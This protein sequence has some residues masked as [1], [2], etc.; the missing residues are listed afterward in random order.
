MEIKKDNELRI[1]F[2]D[3][4]AILQ[5]FEE[6]LDEKG[7][8]WIREL[9][10]SVNGEPDDYP[11]CRGEYVKFMVNLLNEIADQLG[12]HYNKHEKWNLEIK[13]KKNR[14]YEGE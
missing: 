10:T 7:D 11:N 4:G 8:V 5:R 13:Q 9:I 6:D 2:I 3:N 14:D 1:K 12:Y